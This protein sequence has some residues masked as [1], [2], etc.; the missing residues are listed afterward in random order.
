MVAGQWVASRASSVSQHVS[1]GI[2]GVVWCR[3]RARVW[4][5]RSVVMHAR[6]WSAQGS[7]QQSGTPPPLTAAAVSGG[8]PRQECSGV[9][10]YTNQCCDESLSLSRGHAV[11]RK[12]RRC[13]DS[14]FEQQIHATGEARGGSGELSMDL[15]CPLHASQRPPLASRRSV[16]CALQIL[17]KFSLGVD[18]R[19]A[20]RRRVPCSFLR[21]R[22]GARRAVAGRVCRRVCRAA[23]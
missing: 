23:A 16:G 11:H 14:D 8:K 21:C 13:D 2:G 7:G 15:T 18:K 10:S 9:Y 12:G 5:W 4:C 22:G 3:L 20:L 6:C 17:E 19:A 1:C